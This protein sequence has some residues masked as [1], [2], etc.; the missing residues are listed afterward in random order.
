MRRETMERFMTAARDLCL[1]RGHDP[2]ARVFE[3]DGV[4]LPQGPTNIVLAVGDLYRHA[5]M[6]YVMQKY[7][8]DE[9]KTSGSL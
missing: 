4:A 9:F 6:N 7:G 8:I 3:R 1:L 5:Q 2:D